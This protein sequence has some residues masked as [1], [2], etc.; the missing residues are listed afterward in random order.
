MD[1]ETID[2]GTADLRPTDRGTIDYPTIHTRS[3]DRKRAGI[4]ARKLPETGMK[5]DH[6][7]RS[8]LEQLL[9]PR[10]Y[11]SKSE[12]LKLYEY[13]GGIDKARPDYVVFPQTTDDVVAIVKLANELA[14]PI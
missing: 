1:R 4:P 14:I 10:G 12:D 11:L 6:D 7:V 5:R 8:R 9:G 3:R 2:C 13:D